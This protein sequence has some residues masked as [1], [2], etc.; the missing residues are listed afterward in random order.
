MSLGLWGGVNVN[1]VVGGCHIP[2]GGK[3]GGVGS[4]ISEVVTDSEEESEVDGGKTVLGDN[5]REL[6]E[7]EVEVDGGT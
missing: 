7:V 5:D 3:T 1:E 4:A 2:V 6:E